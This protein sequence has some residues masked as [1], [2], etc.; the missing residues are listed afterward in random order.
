[1]ECSFFS[2]YKHTHRD[3]VAALIVLKAMLIKVK[4]SSVNSFTSYFCKGY[5]TVKEHR[6]NHIDDKQHLALAYPARIVA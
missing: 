4:N 1:M 6:Y 2:T 5:E 3:V